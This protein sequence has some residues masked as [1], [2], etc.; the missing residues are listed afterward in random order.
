VS[1]VE[2][3]DYEFIPTVEMESRHAVDEPTVSEFSLI[4]DL[5]GVMAA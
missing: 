1:D 5:F 3:T 2:W 4:Y